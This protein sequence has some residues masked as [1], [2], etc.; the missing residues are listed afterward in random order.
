M[1]YSWPDRLPNIMFELENCHL[2]DFECLVEHVK[3]LGYHIAVIWSLSN[4]NDLIDKNIHRL[5]PDSNRRILD[6]HKQNLDVFHTLYKRKDLI[7]NFDQVIAIDRYDRETPII[8]SL[9]ESDSLILPERL[10]NGVA[11]DDQDIIDLEYIDTRMH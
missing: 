6:I 10:F 4:I 2:E 9:K 5:S 11:K 1:H 7:K 8:S 3:S